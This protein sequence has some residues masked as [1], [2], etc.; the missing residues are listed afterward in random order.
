MRRIRIGFIFVFA[1]LAG[2]TS[3]D[4]PDAPRPDQRP[5][6]TQKLV[7]YAVNYPLAWAAEQLAGESTEVHF[8]APPDIDP[9][10]WEPDI[11]IIAAYQAADLILLNGAKYAR[12]IGK[13]SLPQNRLLDTSRAFTEDYIA[14][15]S[16]PVHS[17]GP[18]GDH[19]HGELAFTT[20]LD[21]GLYALQVEAIAAALTER[22]PEQ[23][24][25]IA[26]RQT[27]LVGE[28]MALDGT[29]IELGQQLNGAPVLYSHP[30]YQYFSRRYG[31]NGLAL[32][33]EPDQRVA[34]SD[35]AELDTVLQRHPAV[36]WNRRISRSSCSGRWAT[37]PPRA[38]S[39]P[40]WQAMWPR[41]SRR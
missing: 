32:H 10:F 6:R 41:W 31:I 7:V 38:I 23:E 29:L 16:G 11:K 39:V 9:A 13:V 8:P 18:E 20:W 40:V 21:L 15:D 25:A 5:A 14:L 17:H 12:W 30:V 27:A 19:S 24:D 33:W 26:Q 1:W 34:E 22:L 28:L 3:C 35:W 36:L 4:P 2:L 37:D